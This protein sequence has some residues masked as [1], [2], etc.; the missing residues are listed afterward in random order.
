MT[1]LVALEDVHVDYVVPRSLQGWMTGR[2][3]VTVQA[4]RGVS[5]SLAPGESLGVVGAN[6]AGKSTLLAVAAGGRPATR[7][8]VRCAVPARLLLDLG[9]ELNA[10]LSTKGNLVYKLRR[11]GLTKRQALDRLD[12]VWDF[13]ELDSEVGELPLRA[14]SAGMLLRLSFASS[15]VLE[16]ELL[17]IDEVLAVGDLAFQAKCA[18][19]ITELRRRGTALLFVSH[20]L[21]QV[22]ATA[23]HA[24]WLDHGRV[25]AAGEPQ[26]VLRSYREHRLPQ[27]GPADVRGTVTVVGATT[28]RVEAGARDRL[29][30]QLPDLVTGASCRL[31]LRREALGVMAV[32]ERTIPVAS[33]LGVELQ[34]SVSD[35]AYWLDIEVLDS[36]GQVV[37]ASPAAVTYEVAARAGNKGIADLDMSVTAGQAGSDPEA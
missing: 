35:G 21:E 18:E 15:V 9:G 33:G 14:L 8:S 3:P 10:E 16:P 36:D 37:A 20:V 34:L 28:R 23:T 30:L 11:L 24:I 4:L 5:L 25:I 1:A 22:E 13:A 31:T 29:H 32:A 7:G 6:G 17:L 2:R 12:E 27:A 26:H 19:R